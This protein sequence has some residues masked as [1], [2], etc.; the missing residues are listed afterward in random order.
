MAGGGPPAASQC[1]QEGPGVVP[2]SGGEGLQKMAARGWREAKRTTPPTPLQG[3]HP[4]SG[5]CLHANA[6][7]PQTRASRRASACMA[8]G[9]VGSDGR[10]GGWGQG[11]HCSSSHGGQAWPRPGG[12]MRPPPPPPPPPALCPSTVSSTPYPTAPMPPPPLLQVPHPSP[13][14]P[15]PMLP[16]PPPPPP[17][18]SPGS[19]LLSMPCCPP[20]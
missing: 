17:P 14:A 16:L 7:D 2:M 19:G 9:M 6:P 18:P 8:R 20:P 12:L 4:P 5:E 11:H 3:D 13:N 15:P 1:Y 10:G